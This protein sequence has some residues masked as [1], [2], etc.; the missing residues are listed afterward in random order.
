MI[1]TILKIIYIL[2]LSIAVSYFTGRI[3][4]RRSDGEGFMISLATG[5]IVLCAAFFVISVPLIYLKKT[6]STVSTAFITVSL[7]TTVAGI[8]LSFIDIS[9]H[10]TEP[11]ALKKEK[12]KLTKEE[13]AYL[14]IF[15][16]LV[17]FQLYKA[18]A[19]KVNDG[20]D[21]FY[22]AVAQNASVSGNMY[23]N[24]PYTGYVAAVPYRYALAPFPIL[25]AVLSNI[26][27]LNAVTMTHIA[28]PLLLIPI[29]YVIYNAI[30]LQLFGENRCKR[31]M[32]LSL[33]AVFAMMSNYT[34]NTAETFMLSRSRQGKEALA[35]IVLPY[36]F[37]FFLKL[38]KEEKTLVKN[39]IEIILLGLS[40]ALCSLFGNVLIVI[41]FGGYFI[42]LCFR[43]SPIKDRLAIACAC[44]P[45]LCVMLL[46]AKLM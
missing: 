24:D 10:E 41:M 25:M 45:N 46:Y 1:T 23:Q 4:N 44:V 42:Y 31:Y 14:G 9:K 11:T 37:Y 38:S 39:I 28:A 43:K 15:I 21:A 22:V 26:A 18:V 7:L 33:L 36:A 30:G 27:K 3:F 20:D 8:V 32:F 19:Y 5:F 2:I 16:G 29:T 6:I 13:I 12:K 35:A 34:V 17:V 40:A